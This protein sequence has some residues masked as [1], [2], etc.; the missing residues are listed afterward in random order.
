M[1]FPLH[2]EYMEKSTGNR[3]SNTIQQHGLQGIVTVS[4]KTYRDTY[5][6]TYQKSRCVSLVDK[7]YR[8]TPMLMSGFLI[9]FWGFN[10][11][12][13][14]ISAISWRPVLVVEEAGEN[15]RPWASN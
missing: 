9:D 10:A 7:V 8:Y 1:F 6:N 5:H 15:H 12:F 13:G 3:T 14:N 4:Y 2:P 11:T